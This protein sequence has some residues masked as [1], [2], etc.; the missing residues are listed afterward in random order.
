MRAENQK[1]WL[2]TGVSSG[3]GKELVRAISEAGDIAVGTVRKQEQLAI[4]EDVDPG[5]TFA[6]LL[7]VRDQDQVHQV[8]SQVH[9]RFG[10]IDVVVNNAGYGLIGAVEEASAEETRQQLDTNVFGALFVTQAVLPYMREQ[11]NGHLIQVSSIGGFV[12]YTGAGIYNASKYALEGF[13]EAI[14][15][16]AGHLGIKV[17]MVEPGP[18]R[19]E[20]AGTSMKQTQRRID[21]YQASVGAFREWL[22][23]DNGQQVGDPYLAAKAMVTLAHDSNPP[24]NFPV[25]ESAIAAMREK[26]ARLSVEIDKW[27]QLS[28]NTAFK[29][30]Q[31]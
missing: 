8:V 14:A 7:D 25:G 13:S 1:I 12:S 11:K 26:I 5:N 22:A 4:T 10:S 3:F 20:W 31:V 27:E 2:V 28:V 18:F 9:D 21:D 29:G 19:T 30:A 16:E 15:K 23:G 24:L 6:Y 17:T